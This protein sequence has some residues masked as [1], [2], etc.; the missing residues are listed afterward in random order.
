M[1][2]APVGSITLNN[3]KIDY[4]KSYSDSITKKI[5]EILIDIQNENIEDPFGWISHL[6]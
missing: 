5:R 2:V 1:I 3:K 6:N 4:K